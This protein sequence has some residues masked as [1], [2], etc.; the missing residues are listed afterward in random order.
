[1]PEFP[2]PPENNADNFERHFSQ[3]ADFRQRGLTEEEAHRLAYLIF[4]ESKTRL[5]DTEYEEKIK[6]EDK[7]G[8]LDGK[9]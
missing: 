4:V 3:A 6:L 2:L 1:M 5:S 7:L 8:R 9:S